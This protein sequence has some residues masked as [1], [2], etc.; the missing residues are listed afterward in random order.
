MSSNGQEIE[1]KLPLEDKEAFI[2][3]LE[4]AGAQFV[5]AKTQDDLLFRCLTRDFEQSDEALRLRIEESE[6]KTEAVLTYK[7]T[8]HHTED[9][10]KVRDEF[11]THVS[12]PE[13]MQ[14]I[15]TVTAFTQTPSE[16][17]Y[18]KRR[19]Y[20]LDGVEVTIDELKF[21]DFVE[22]EGTSE[23]IQ[24]LRH[25][26]DLEQVEPVSRGYIFLQWDWEKEHPGQ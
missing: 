25:K 1:L 21:G 14:K 11:E 10:H 23:E 2:T 13:M 7:G 12:D 3:K 20:T 8:P 26:L 17:I 16:R 24:V 9:G 18:K 4:A 22:L 15:L 19:T 5:S 6:G